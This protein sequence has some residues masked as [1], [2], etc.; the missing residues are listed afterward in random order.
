[1]AYK[2]KDKVKRDKLK[3]DLKDMED[4]VTPQ[5]PKE[6]VWEMTDEMCEW[7]PHELIRD[8]VNDTIDVE[9]WIC[10]E[11]G[12]QDFRPKVIE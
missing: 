7:C 10:T 5:K 2:E 12:C 6:E 11:C 8:E 4:G 1:M 3:K 9:S